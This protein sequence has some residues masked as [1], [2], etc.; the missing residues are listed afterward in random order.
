MILATLA[1]VSAVATSAQQQPVPQSSAEMISRVLAT[2]YNN[3]QG[4]GKIDLEVTAGGQTLKVTTD[5]QFQ[6]PNKFYLK[7]QMH[8]AGAKPLMV[9]CDGTAFAYPVANHSLES[10]KWSYVFEPLR[11][12]DTRLRTI[13]EVY[14]AGAVGLQ[15]RSLVLDLVVARRSDIVFISKSLFDYKYHGRHKVNGQ[16]TY[17][18]SGQFKSNLVE[19]SRGAFKMYISDD[20][21]LVRYVTQESVEVQNG[22]S[23]TTQ[24]AW[25]LTSSVNEEVKIN[26]S[27]FVIP[28]GLK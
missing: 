28:S 7:Q 17:L 24:M 4:A 25:N 23:V 19:K 5:Y 12:R 22:K 18:V 3:V 21:K 16:D 8:K 6:R 10:N 14:A 15:D 9:I 27:L 2:Y 26:K 20:F 13:D 1:S 11:Q